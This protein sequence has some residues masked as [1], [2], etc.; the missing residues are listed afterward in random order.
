MFIHL[1][2]AYLSPANHYWSEL[3]SQS[4]IPAPILIDYMHVVVYMESYGL[5]W[6]CAWLFEYDYVG[7]IWYDP[8]FPYV[9][10]IWF[11]A[12]D[13]ARFVVISTHDPRFNSNRLLYALYL[14]VQFHLD[15]WIPDFY[16]SSQC[17]W[18]MYV[19]L[20]MLTHARSQFCVSLCNPPWLLCFLNI[21]IK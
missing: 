18:V 1:L 9:G 3:D 20:D 7:C 2:F 6:S 14:L 15:A 10:I 5:W 4:L 21:L 8:R 19:V 16:D 17:G 12:R 11:R 13:Y